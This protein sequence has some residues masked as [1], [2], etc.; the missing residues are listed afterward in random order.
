MRA[1]LKITGQY[2]TLENVTVTRDGGTGP[3]WK[4]LRG[5]WPENALARVLNQR[6]DISGSTGEVLLRARG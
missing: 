5:Q 4:R 1:I 3:D 6:K 2:S